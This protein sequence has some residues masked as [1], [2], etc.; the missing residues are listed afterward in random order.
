MVTRKNSNRERQ[1]N[2]TGKLSYKVMKGLNVCAFI[3][4]CCSNLG[5]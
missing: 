5:I 3:N 2:S 1:D 4:E